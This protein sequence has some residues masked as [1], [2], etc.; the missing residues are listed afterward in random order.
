MTSPRTSPGGASRPSTSA[1]CRCAS[2]DSTSAAP[3]HYIGRVSVTDVDQDPIVVDWRAPVAEPF[4]RA[5]AVEPM[6]VVRRRHFLTRPGEGRVLVGLDDEV[7]DRGRGRSRGS[8][9]DRRGRAARRA[10]ARRTGRMGDI[11]ATIQA[12]Q[13]EAIRA[14]LPG[15]LVV[16][17]RCRHRQDRRRAAPRRLPPLHAPAPP[18]VRWRAARRA[19]HDLPALH[20]PGAPVARRGRRAARDPAGSSPRT[21]C[22]PRTRPTSRR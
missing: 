2:G 14:A 5:T 11:V 19:E 17:R 21:G 10:R 7:F 13:D 3:T 20:R 22:V 12:E 8:R 16:H 6:D 18:R 4:Y 1:I 9:G 15:V